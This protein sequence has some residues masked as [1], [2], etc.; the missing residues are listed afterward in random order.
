MA[1]VIFVTVDETEYFYTTFAFLVG[2]FTSIGSG[3]LAMYVATG[4]NY[5]TTLQTQ[6]GLR[7]GFRCAY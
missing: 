2:G 5:R 6:T 1:V 7:H 3:Y 4:S